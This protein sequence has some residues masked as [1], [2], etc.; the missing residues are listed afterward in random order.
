VGT[1]LSLWYLRKARDATEGKDQ[2]KK[3]PI[4]MIIL[5][6]SEDPSRSFFCNFMDVKP[7]VCASTNFGLGL[8][9]GL[10]IGN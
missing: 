3:S 8:G 6:L 5:R 10:E 9:L 7:S 1:I 2:E 4:W